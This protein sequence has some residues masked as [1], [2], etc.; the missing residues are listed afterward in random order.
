[1]NMNTYALAAGLLL[2]LLLSSCQSGNPS[3]PQEKATIAIIPQPQEVTPGEG[4]WLLDGQS[5]LYVEDA[6]SAW[7]QLAAFAG[8]TL[9]KHTGLALPN[10]AAATASLRIEHNPA[11]L[12]P[13]GYGLAVDDNGIIITASQPAGAFYGLQTLLQLLPATVYDAKAS[14]PNHWWV[15]K[16]SIKD[17]PRFAWRGMHL[18]VARH[19]FDVATIKQYIDMLAIHKQ[20]YFHWH[21]TDDQGWRIEIKQYPK[22]TDIAAWRRETLI[23]HYNDQPQRFDGKRY[24]GY[25]TQEEVREIVRYAAERYVTVVPEIEMPG[26]AQAAIAA[27]PELA[28]TP[29]PFEPATKWGVFEDVFCPKEETFVF[30]ENVLSEVMALFPSPYIHIGGDECPKVRWE[31]SDFCQQLMRREGLKDE[32]ELQSYFIRRI[33]KYLNANGRKLIGW[34]EILEGGLAPNA[35]VMSWRGIE[36]G[37][38]AARSGHQVI[39][40]PT[41][42]C[43]FDYYQAEHPDE[44]LAIGGLLPLEKVYSYEPVPA[45]LSETEA[46]YILGAQGNVWTEYIPTTEKLQ[47]MVWPRASA[48]AEVGW[49]ARERRNY[50]DFAGRLWIHMERLRSNG[51]K[52]ADHLNQVK[53]DVQAGDG[54]GV[55]ARLFTDAPGNTIRYT[56]DGRTPDAQSPVYETPILLEGEVEL[57]ALPFMGDQVSGRAVALSYRAHLASGKAIQLAHMPNEKYTGNGPGSVVNGVLG[58]DQRYGD[59]EWLGF[60]QTNFA[61]DIDLGSSTAINELKFRFYDAPG[62]WIYLPKMIRVSVSE[63]GKQF[64]AAGSLRQLPASEGNICRVPLPVQGAKG[65]YVRV[66]VDRLGKIPAG[67]SG[68]GHEAWL[69]I[70]EIEIR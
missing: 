41:S 61:A 66:E 31:A 3:M 27:Y 40:S 8:E 28:C 36:G 60:D 2:S 16:V 46:R 45:E 49:T 23:G 47:Y 48:M 54:K 53:A 34:D 25:Y 38:A 24:G 21:L 19:Y 55:R 44:P 70:D 29:G 5:T 69:F 12:A 11:I 17:A 50:A 22:L 37:I 13:E 42:H 15:P 57:N 32:M 39:M 65:R 9:R 6:D 63:D 43:Y 35:T 18:D 62:Q 1:M 52:P 7:R 4:Y 51:V 33:E 14:K 59:A 64:T 20:N 56:L 30:L 58:S 67:Q 10:A 68:A 26:H